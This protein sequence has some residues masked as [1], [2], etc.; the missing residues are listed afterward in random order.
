VRQKTANILSIQNLEAGNRGT[1]ISANE[2]KRLT[3]ASVEVLYDDEH[4]AMALTT[5]LAVID[6]LESRIGLLEKTIQEG[7]TPSRV[8]DAPTVW[9]IGRITIMYEAGDMSRF[10]SPG[11]SRRTAAT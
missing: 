3:A 7:A 11:T 2:V 6:T 10:A 5:I 9:S 1:K 4:L 8:G